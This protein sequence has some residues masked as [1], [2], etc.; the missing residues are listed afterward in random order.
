MQE[1]LKWLVR[2]YVDGLYDEDKYRPRKRSMEIEFDSLVVPQAD[3][4]AEAG[5]LI[6][7]LRELWARA[8]MEDRR[9]LLLTMLD[10]VYIVAKVEKRIVAIK[11]KAPFRPISQVATTEGGLRC[12][13]GP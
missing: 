11:P 7:R 1:Q 2:A 9:R 3:A 4:A 12:S 13:P 6:E 8:S 5:R 10:A